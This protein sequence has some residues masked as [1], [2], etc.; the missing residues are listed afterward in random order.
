MVNRKKATLPVRAMPPDEIANRA[1][2]QF[3]TRLPVKGFPD[4][5]QI[6]E[7]MNETERLIQEMLCS[8]AVLR[9]ITGQEKMEAAQRDYLVLEMS[10]WLTEHPLQLPAPTFTE[11][12]NGFKLALVTVLGTFAMGL[13]LA[14]GFNFLAEDPQTG[15]KLGS[16]IGAG[17]T[18][19]LMW[20]CSENKKV[21]RY[22]TAAL[23]VAS[24]AEVAILFGKLSGIGAI[25][26]ALT[27]NLRG[28]G[29]FSAIKRVAVYVSI[30]F[31]LRF[32]VR[33]PVFNRVEYEKNLR[34][35]FGLWLDHAL[36]FLR[37]LG[38][39]QRKMPAQTSD[40]LVKI[41]RSLGL[42]LHKLHRSSP[43]DLPAAASEMIAAART[44]GFEGLDGDPAFISG[45]S[46]EPEQFVWEKSLAEKF[47][48][49]G[50]IE[51]GDPV[52]VASP[53]VVQDGKVIEKGS[54][55]KVRR[56]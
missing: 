47:N 37:Q 29:F 2:A 51:E 53:P 19:L 35:C 3:V 26:S 1:V 32:S 48:T 13:L 27:A 33:Q 16:M 14:G 34:V 25:W 45:K 5:R 44:L 17:G 24:A 30:V 21:R 6:R 56:R 39:L 41:P 54:V 49:L 7:A 15:W 20:Y 55:R 36:T 11:R 52:F 43:E 12:L 18:V 10:T 28:A 4:E 40:K 42:Y 50:I 46:E 38:Q 8:D 31:L 23:G 9:E 22:L